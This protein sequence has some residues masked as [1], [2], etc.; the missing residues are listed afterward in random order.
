ML[1]RRRPAHRRQ[2][3]SRANSDLHGFRHGAYIS[4]GAE[5]LRSGHMGLVKVLSEVRSWF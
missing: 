1:A 3:K 5:I 4:L 2:S